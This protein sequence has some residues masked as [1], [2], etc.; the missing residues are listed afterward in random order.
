MN[1]NTKYDVGQEVWFIDKN[2][3]ISEKILKINFNKSKD[4]EII[5]YHFLEAENTSDWDR[6]RLENQIFNSKE[7]LIL[8]L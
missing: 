4:E 1:I 5:T 2:E 3:I 8:S 6:K 7:D